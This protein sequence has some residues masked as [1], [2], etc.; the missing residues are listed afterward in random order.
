MDI[1]PI[2]KGEQIFRD[3]AKETRIIIRQVKM[4]VNQFMNDNLK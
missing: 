1:E 2:E 3:Y 4:Q